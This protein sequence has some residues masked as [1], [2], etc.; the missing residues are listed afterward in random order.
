MVPLMKCGHTANA[1]DQDNN[2]VCVICNCREIARTNSAMKELLIRRK[3]RC[4][5]CGRIEDSNLNLAFF[6][7]K[8][9][10]D[11]DSYYCGCYGWD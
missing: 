1:V 3:A 4:F 7:Y 9:L 11:Y 6:E 8:P 5:E 2:P 10:S